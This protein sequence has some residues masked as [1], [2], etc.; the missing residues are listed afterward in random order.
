MI[1]PDDIESLRGIPSG[2][3]LGVDFGK[4]RVGLAMSDPFQMMASTLQTCNAK[5][6]RELLKE[7]CSL[8]QSHSVIAIVIGRPLHMSGERGTLA[9]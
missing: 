1:L 4:K 8:I 2:R 6:Q 5:D 9:A 3:I 7:I